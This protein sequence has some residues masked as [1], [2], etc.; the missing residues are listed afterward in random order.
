[1]IVQTDTKSSAVKHCAWI[2]RTGNGIDCTVLQTVMTGITVTAINEDA[3]TAYFNRWGSSIEA[4]E[5]GVMDQAVGGMGMGDSAE[6]NADTDSPGDRQTD[7]INVI[8]VDAKSS[9]GENLYG[10]DRINQRS[11]NL[12]SKYRY[13]PPSP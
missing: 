2:E 13:A 7:G 1:M 3:L 6:D 5:A 4:A 12:D 10:L 8:E 11:N 9:S